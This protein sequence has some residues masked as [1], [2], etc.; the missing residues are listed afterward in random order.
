M[1]AH[2][3]LYF[4]VLHQSPRFDSF[5][6]AASVEGEEEQE[7]QQTRGFA[8]EK[9]FDLESWYTQ[10]AD[11]TFP[12]AFVPV[13]RQ[14]ARAILRSYRRVVLK[15]HGE[16]EIEQQ[17]AAEQGE[18]EH[19]RE[20]GQVEQRLQELAGR[21][22][23]AM[24][25][26]ER[27]CGSGGF[28]V[29]MSSRSPKDSALGCQRMKRLLAEQLRASSVALARGHGPQWHQNS[30]FIAF[31]RA[32]IQALRV[33]HAAEALDLLVQSERV[34]EDLKLALAQPVASWEQR[35]AIRAWSRRPSDISGEFR[36]F[37]RQRRLTA[38][39]QYFHFLCFAELLG[40]QADIV[41][42][43][44]SFFTRHVRHR[45]P[46]DDCIMDVLLPFAV[47]PASGSLAVPALIDP[48]A[49]Q[50]IEFNPF[51]R[52]TSP[53]LFS[54][55][56]DRRIIV[57]K[58]PLQLRLRLEPF[59]QRVTTQQTLDL[60]HL[61]PDILQQHKEL[62][63]LVSDFLEDDFARIDSNLR[64]IGRAERLSQII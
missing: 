59:A 45:L 6:S 36:C 24:D 60:S 64:Y 10:F 9:L 38:I 20:L 18:E 47:D 22:Q 13:S 44:D 61:D 12:S 58:A 56:R 3:Q 40:R 43:I 4:L 42:A 50:L 16:E 8:Y 19:Q 57:G 23:Q 27:S 37:V 34:F 25:D 55:T 14:E 21:A 41:A 51:N 53:C 39:S 48:D 49:I 28:F 54:W 32:Q 62:L 7:I 15:G 35:L 30:E 63:D 1:A 46:F 11:V 52:F 17:A 5:A 26:M 2:L 29:R 33:C 31:F